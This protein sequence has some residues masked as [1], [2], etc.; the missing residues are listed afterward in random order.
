[1]ALAGSAAAQLRCCASTV[2]DGVVDAAVFRH[3]AWR[4]RRLRLH[5]WMLSD[6]LL[7]A[8]W[9]PPPVRRCHR[10]PHAAMAALEMGT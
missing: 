6:L 3:A 10:A 8:A 1:M 2:N 4:R 7:I 5:R 9:A